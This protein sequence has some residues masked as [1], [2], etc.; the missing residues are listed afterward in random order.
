MLNIPEEIKEALKDMEEEQN[1][2]AAML[3]S[4]WVLGELMSRGER[5]Y[6]LAEEAKELHEDRKELDR[7]FKLT[8]VVMSDGAAE[9]EEEHNCRAET[10]AIPV[11][12]PVGGGPAPKKPNFEET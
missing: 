8:R 2:T 4:V 5:M 6:K 7:L 1:K 11:P 3:V 9:I 10:L 12:K